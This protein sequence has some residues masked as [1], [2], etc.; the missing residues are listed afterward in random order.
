M[1]AANALGLVDIPSVLQD[2]HDKLFA[3]PNQTNIVDFAV[4]KQ[5]TTLSEYT[6]RLFVQSFYDHVNGAHFLNWD[7]RWVNNL[8]SHE[9]IPIKVRYSFALSLDEGQG[10][11]KS[12]L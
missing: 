10:E 12:S 6:W 7:V 9:D 2:Y 5:M 8:L 1:A 11:K 4:C 3:A